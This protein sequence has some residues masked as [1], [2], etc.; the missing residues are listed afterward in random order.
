MLALVPGIADF[1]HKDPREK[2][3]SICKARKLTEAVWVEIKKCISL[4]AVCHSLVHSRYLDDS[5]LKTVGEMFISYEA[6]KG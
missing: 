6:G 4:C 3:F 1:H 5:S 2:D